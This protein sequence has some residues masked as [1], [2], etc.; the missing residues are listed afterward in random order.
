MLIER[1]D[2]LINLCEMKFSR[3]PYTLTEE[4]EMQLR[5]RADDFV[6]E[7]GV[8]HGILLTMITTYGL[9]QNSR[10]GCVDDMVTMEHLFEKLA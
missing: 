10:S 7:T 3:M 2:Q 5:I 4:E 9:R 1:S 8:R 6:R